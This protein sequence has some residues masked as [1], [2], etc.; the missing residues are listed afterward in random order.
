MVLLS[1]LPIRLSQVIYV[2]IHT[3]THICICMGVY[4]YL[5]TFAAETTSIGFIIDLYLHI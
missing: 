3:T 4:S 1:D 2:S 5:N